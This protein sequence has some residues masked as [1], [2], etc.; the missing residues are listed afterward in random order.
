M[1]LQSELNCIHNLTVKKLGKIILVIFIMRVKIKK[2]V[3]AYMLMSLRL[4]KLVL[5]GT[6]GLD[7]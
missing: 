2:I 4:Q 5:N 1:G 6:V 7:L 3:G